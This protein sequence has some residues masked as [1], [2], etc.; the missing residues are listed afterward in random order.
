LKNKCLLSKWL[1]KLITEEGMWQQLLHNK[2]LKHMTLSQVEVKPTN[3]PFWKG[4]MRVK[5]DFFTR[6]FFS[7]SEMDLLCAFGKMFGWAILL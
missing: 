1:F 7:K 5:N 3:A 6:V 2:Y 4:L